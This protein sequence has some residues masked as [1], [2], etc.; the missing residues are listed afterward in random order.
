MSLT[1]VITKQAFLLVLMLI[2]PTSQSTNQN[3]I[4]SMK[5]SLE[6]LGMAGVVEHKTTGEMF[7]VVR[8]ILEA[9]KKENAEQVNTLK[10]RAVIT[11]D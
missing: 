6:N 7:P 2:A 9:P 10:V 8:K 1:A 3:H 5:K 11:G 4:S